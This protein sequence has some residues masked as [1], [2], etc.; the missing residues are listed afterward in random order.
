MVKTNDLLDF[1]NKFVVTSCI[2]D[3]YFD[4]TIKLI[5]KTNQNRQD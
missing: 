5:E 3:I 2:Y 1:L 4:K